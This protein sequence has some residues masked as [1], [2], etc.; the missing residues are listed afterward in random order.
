MTNLEKLQSMAAEVDACIKVDEE[1]QEHVRLITA[2]TPGWVI[3]VMA[4]TGAS[5]W[6]EP[7]PLQVV[8]MTMDAVQRADLE[9]MGLSD[10]SDA[11][12]LAEELRAWMIEA[13]SFEAEQIWTGDLLRWAEHHVDEVE[14]ELRAQ[15]QDINLCNAI[16]AAQQV[17][18]EEAVG[19]VLRALAGAMLEEVG[20]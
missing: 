5:R 20:D 14:D 13:D 11:D 17:W 7:F 6:T 9:S 2:E 1:R 10:L 16:A 3:D 8:A 19:V 12:E 18:A 15:G 4:S